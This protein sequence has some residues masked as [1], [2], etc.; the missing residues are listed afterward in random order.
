MSHCLNV[1]FLAFFVPSTEFTPFG[2]FQTLLY[3]YVRKY[4]YMI[5]K[6]NITAIVKNI[7]VCGMGIK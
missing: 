2:C 5:M 6:R 1:I 3:G 7:S 4:I